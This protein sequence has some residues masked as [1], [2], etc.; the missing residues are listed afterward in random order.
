[1]VTGCAGLL[2]FHRATLLSG[3]DVVQADVGDSRLVVFLLEHWHRVFA[4]NA[5]WASPSM[6]YPVKGVLGYSDMLFGTGSAFIPLFRKFGLGLFQAA[7]ATMVL[8]SLL[9]YLS[10]VLA[11]SPGSEDCYLEVSLVPSSSRSPIRSSPSSAHLQLRFDFFQPLALGVIA[12]LLLEDAGDA[13]TRTGDED[14]HLRWPGVSCR[15]HGVL[16][17]MVFRVFPVAC[18]RSLQF[19]TSAV[20]TMIVMRLR[21][22]R[23]VLWIPLLLCVV[24]LAPFLTIYLPSLKLG[25]DR[26]WEN[27]IEYLPRLSSY[28]WLGPEHLL[29][30]SLQFN[31]SKALCTA[32]ENHLGVRRCRHK[33]RVRRVG[34]GHP[35]SCSRHSRKQSV[36]RPSVGLAVGDSRQLAHRDRVDGALGLVLSLEGRL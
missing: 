3:F 29:W 18:R 30:G 24:M 8:L 34:V 2:V 23:R 35:A 5:E 12:P 15:F 28:L 9:A 36:V 33:S 10:C 20:R 32:I 6:F 13:P 7:N 16:Q 4:W 31:S 27:T 26:N 19:R 14:E 1:M 25:I 11:P 17:R 21:E 22:A